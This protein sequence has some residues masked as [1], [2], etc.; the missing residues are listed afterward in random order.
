MKQKTPSL[1]NV[2]KEASN[3]EILLISD[4][5]SP[6]TRLRGQTP[7][8]LNL[9]ILIRIFESRQNQRERLLLTTIIFQYV[10]KVAELDTFTKLSLFN[11]LAEFAFAADERFFGGWGLGC[12]GAAD[13]ATA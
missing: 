2:K 9:H 12:S 8:N 7:I 10:N 3:E 6:N 1:M 4:P 11:A 5:A 13:G